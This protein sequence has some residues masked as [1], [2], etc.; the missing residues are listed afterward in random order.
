LSPLNVA[1]E[2]DKQRDTHSGVIGWVIEM[3]RGTAGAKH[4]L[5]G[6][7]DQAVIV[8]RHENTLHTVAEAIG[9]NCS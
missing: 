2:T 8:G 5:A 4:P 6:N 3:E 9:A 1:G 7:G